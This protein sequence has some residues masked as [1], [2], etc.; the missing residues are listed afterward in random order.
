MSNNFLCSLV[1]LVGFGGVV[2]TS[3]QLCTQRAMLRM[4]SDGVG[5]Y[6]AL[7]GER[8]LI[9]SDEM[10]NRITICNSV[11]LSY[12]TSRHPT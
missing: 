6:Y 7:P 5:W 3:L 4:E 10:Q 8:V 2:N 1:M 9:E 11:A 12:I